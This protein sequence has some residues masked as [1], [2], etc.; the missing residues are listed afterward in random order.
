MARLVAFKY[1]GGKYYQLSWLLSLLP[2]CQH[3]CEPFCGAAYVTLNREP[4]KVE[5]INDLKGDVVNF[6]KV[7]RDNGEE[8]IEKLRLT[9][10]AREEFVNAINYDGDEEIERARCFY[11]CQ[12][13]G[14]GGV[15]NP[16]E[17]KWGFGKQP[18]SY[19]PNVLINCIE[20]LE[21][22]IA[23]LRHIQIDNRPAI[24][25]IKRNDTTDTL[26]YCD[27]PYVA[28]SRVEGGRTTYGNYEMTDD[29][30]RELANVLHNVKGKV[31]ISGHRCELYDELYRN[32]M[33]YDKD[34]NLFAG[35][36]STNESKR[37][38]DSLWCNYSFS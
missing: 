25:V 34:C 14:F 36:N 2:K 20:K 37:R 29:D 19:L 11:V 22:I 17:G 5:T 12:R 30:H 10:Y 7:L 8:L 6:F 32:W 27:P 35:N 33:R 1:Y 15:Q 9:P 28:G 24:D 26:F 21:P 18:D 4:S 23:R 16:T 3:F 13:Q 31:A 38:I